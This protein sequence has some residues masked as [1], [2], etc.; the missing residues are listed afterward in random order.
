MQ[1]ATEHRKRCSSSLVIREMQNKTARQYHFTAM[2]KARFWEMENKCWRGCEELGILVHH[3]WV[4]NGSGVVKLC[5]SSTYSTPNYHVTQQL[6]SWV[7]TRSVYS[8]GVSRIENRDSNKTL[9][10]RCSLHSSIHDGQKEKQAKCPQMDEWFIHRV[11]FSL[12]KEWRTDICHMSQPGKRYMMWS[13]PD[14]E[15][16]ILYGSTS[17]GYLVKYSFRDDK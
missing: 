16:Q 7:Y 11:S 1:M 2:R 3:W 13:K 9:V 14:M 8:H 12:K 17:T 15:E 10:S 4:S 5:S 6:H